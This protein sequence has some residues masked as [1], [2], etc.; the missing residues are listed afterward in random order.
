MTDPPGWTEAEVLYF[1]EEKLARLEQEHVKSPIHLLT[2]SFSHPQEEAAGHAFA[3]QLACIAP[4]GVWAKISGS[5]PDKVVEQFSSY[6]RVFGLTL[7]LQTNFTSWT[8]PYRL[9]GN[10]V[11]GV[12]VSS[13]VFDR[14]CDPPKLI[15]VASLHLPV[16]ALSEALGV[17]FST[18][19]K[20]T[21]NQQ[22]SK[23]LSHSTVV[24]R[25]EPSA[26]LLEDFRTAGPAGDDASCDIDCPW[27]SSRSSLCYQPTDLLANRALESVSVEERTC[28]VKDEEG[29]CSCYAPHTE[30]PTFTPTL[31][32][33][34]DP[35]VAPT[36]LGTSYS[37]SDN[38]SDDPKVEVLDEDS[39]D[40]PIHNYTTSIAPTSPNGTNNYPP[41][42]TGSPSASPTFDHATET[43]IS[44]SPTYAGGTVASNVPSFTIP[45]TL[46]PTSEGA[47][48]LG[49]PDGT[50][51]FG[52]PTISSPSIRSP[53]FTPTADRSPTTDDPKNSPT[54]VDSPTNGG[55]NGFPTRDVDT[56]SFTPSFSPTFDGVYPPFPW[57]NPTPTISDPS[58]PASGG[59]PTV[60]DPSDPTIE[61]EPTVN[62]PTI[63]FVPPTS[64]LEP[65]VPP[66][67][68]SNETVDT[69]TPLDSSNETSAPGNVSIIPSQSA[70]S[71]D[72]DVLSSPLIWA[73]IVPLVI[74]GITGLVLL[75][76]YGRNRGNEY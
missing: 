46:S 16:S 66:V 43:P 55:P 52:S 3:K 39:N 64:G 25:L 54:F 8:L 12:S 71:N 61:G 73:G 4:H 49:D 41:T 59:V 62:S 27:V 11:Q 17:A 63:V 29:R 74:I 31:S 10:Y 44:L 47:P 35:T 15:G 23:L 2:Y 42:S 68:Y 38:P 30:H 20:E 45:S 58:E 57:T 7:G 40:T 9:A 6:Y 48:S 18:C 53:T 65:T 75:V 72:N 56:P 5:S 22:I 32:L 13:P 67:I 26:C 60:N 14:S 1:V 19:D 36:I 37:P 50:P 33:T 51:T 76:M 28:C 24:P 70:N 69:E 21:M 34:T